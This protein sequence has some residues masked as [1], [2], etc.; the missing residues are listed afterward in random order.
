MN[1]KRF[2]VL[3][4]ETTGNSPKK[5][6]K[7][8]QIGAVVIDDWK[9]SK[10]ISY[11]V[12]PGKKIPPFIEKL[13]GI[14]D[15]TVKHE[16]SFLEIADEVYDLL[17]Q[18]Y[19][20]AHNIHFDTSFV[21]S[22]LKNAGYDKLDCMVIDTVEL[23]RILFPSFGGYK[24]TELSE[25]LQIH[26]ESPHRADSDAEV[27]SRIFLEMVK[28]LKSLPIP[29]LTELKRLSS[30][31]ISD[32]EPLLDDIL[33]KKDPAKEIDYKMVKSIAVK[34]AES[35]ALEREPSAAD[36]KTLND[37]C[38][39]SFSA[40]NVEHREGQQEMMKEVYTSFNNNEHSLIEAA[41]GTGKTLGYLLP[42][43]LFSREKG[44]PITLS[45]YTTLLQ[46]QLV[47]HDIPKLNELLETPVRTAVLKGRSHY[48]NI[49]KLN[50]IMEEKDSNYDTVLTIAQLLVWLLETSTGDVEEINLPSGGK[51]IWDRL[52]CEG[53]LFQTKTN[54]CFYESAKKKAQAADLV[55]TNHSFLLANEKNKS[56]AVP[57]TGYVIIDE[58]HH[59]E[60][61]ALDHTGTRISYLDFHV[62]RIQMGS[63]KNGGLL[64][65]L[66]QRFARFGISAELKFQIDE[67]L[68]FIQE[69]CDVFFSMLHSFVKKRKPMDDV[70]RLTLRLE[71]KQ[72][73]DIAGQAMAEGARRLCSMLSELNSR[74]EGLLRQTE[75]VKGQLDLKGLFVYHEFRSCVAY[76]SWLEQTLLQMFFTE[77]AKRI[78]WIEIDAKGAKN[79]V[80]L[81]DQPLEIAE[82]IAD[83]FF[84]M[85][86]S[87]VLTSATLT[88]DR[89][90]SF[91]IKKLGLTDFYPR[92][93]Q[94]E[95]PYLY[96]KHMRILIP[97][98]M[99]LIHETDQQQYA[100]MT[101]EYVSILAKQ[102]RA[103]ILVLFTSYEMVRGV[104]NKLKQY[105]TLDGELLGQGIT[106][107][108]PA[109]VK[110]AFAASEKAVLL[111]TRQ[112]WE[113]VDFPGNEL[114]TVVI[115]RLP[116]SSPGQPLAKARFDYIKNRGGN[117]FEELSLPE[118]VVLFKQGIGRLI[119]S[120]KDSGTVVILD[121]RI[122]TS[123]YSRTFMNALPHSAVE[124]M[125]KDELE[126][127]IDELND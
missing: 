36:L 43:V 32:L 67:Y 63:F 56:G 7:I 112:Y 30:H 37:I 71:T 72:R 96:K 42:A 15:E 2:V 75:A 41:P 24:L 89:S 87:V 118:A 8:I 66:Q 51:R 38:F 126:R 88:V 34:K 122:L 107:G 54:D 20:V 73:N 5:G 123:S 101:A 92:T 58:A 111:G 29:T 62:K 93:L 95:S 114:T 53:F 3:D 99:P 70:N 4:V 25:A 97:E 55:I 108:S 61:A 1:N 82:R 81:Y 119:R 10:R 83:Q 17:T 78:T 79:A 102:N 85:K 74:F 22:E 124:Q 103:K 14:K 27:T 60:K 65:K 44:V 40:A 80:S 16:R 39:D 45:T 94:I 28:K 26:H 64:K 91:M 120:S 106:A 9:I 47:E 11:F 113:G 18:S 86:K 12:N 49:Y 104:Y 33:R 31:L 90:F 48:L 127:Y 100:K 35:D 13:T 116:F 105:D 57:A 98:H 59:F 50:Y 52:N 115:A 110:K 21:N 76:F 68:E 125:T 19:F 109:K 77:D 69:E 6:D 84:T 117:P 23:A 46:Q 121:R